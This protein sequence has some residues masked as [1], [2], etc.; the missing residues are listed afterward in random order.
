MSREVKPQIYFYIRKG[1][2]EQLIKFCDGVILKRGK[3]PATL[4]W[5]AFGHGMSNNISEC[6][7]LLE[8]FQARNDMQYP[9]P[10]ALLYFHQRSSSLDA[11]SIET[12]SAQIH[13]AKDV[14]VRL[15]IIFRIL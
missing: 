15:K 10:L 5:K 9:V 4:Y 7:R 12:L 11:D 3:D 6:L 1:W 8:G 14:T 13:A 2:Y